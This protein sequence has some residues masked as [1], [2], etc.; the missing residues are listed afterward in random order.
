VLYLIRN[1]LAYRVLLFGGSAAVALLAS[2][3]TYERLL[4]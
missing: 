2:L 4:L 1:T 3:W